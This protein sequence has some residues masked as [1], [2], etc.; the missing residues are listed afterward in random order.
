MTPTLSMKIH[1]E[2]MKQSAHKAKQRSQAVKKA[3][4][5]R[6]R[7]EKASPTQIKILK[8]LTESEDT[9][10]LSAGYNDTLGL[11]GVNFY[12]R[13]YQHGRIRLTVTTFSVLKR[14]KWIEK[15]GGERLDGGTM[16]TLPNGKQ[17]IISRS[18]HVLYKI[19]DKGRKILKQAEGKQ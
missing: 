4:R 9:V 15:D 1:G 2:V 5:T 14:R 7:N 8:A 17:G 11:W 19:T 12:G 16:G 18:Y 10:R 6:K 3:W 13:F